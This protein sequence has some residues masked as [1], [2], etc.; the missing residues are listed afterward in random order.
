RDGG[1]ARPSAG[2]ARRLRFDRRSGG[3]VCRRPPCP[4]PLRRR[5]PLRRARPPAPP[6][7]PPAV[8]GH[9]SA[10]PGHRPLLE[11]IG[12]RPL[13][14]LGMRLG[15]ASGATL[16]FAVLKAAVACHNSMATFSEAGVSGPNQTGPS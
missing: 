10:E 4:R 16:A 15:E 8:A 3:V 14:D 11:Q 13:F 9:P 7:P 6:P 2:A 1:A 12:Q 5:A